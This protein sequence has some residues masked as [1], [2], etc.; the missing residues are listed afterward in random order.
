MLEKREARQGIE[1]ITGFSRARRIHNISATQVLRQAS[2]YDVELFS[3]DRTSN[4]PHTAD[5]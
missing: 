1:R 2:M 5:S 3:R 4:D